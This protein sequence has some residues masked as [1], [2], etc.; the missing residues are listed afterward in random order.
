MSAGD[1]METGGTGYLEH[2]YGTRVTILDNAFLST[3]LARLGSPRIGHPE[4]V[5]ALRILYQALLVNVAGREF[6]RISGEVPT[7]MATAHPAEGVYRGPLLDPGTN[8][9]I[10]DVIRAGLVPSQ[11]C[12]EMLN[13]ALPTVRVRL[14]H[15]TLARRSGEDGHVVGVDLS[16]SKIGG[17][18]EGAVLILPDPMGATGATAIRAVDHYREH[19]GEPAAIIALPMIATPEFLRASLDAI[20]KLTVT[21]LRIDRGLSPPDVLAARPGEFWNRER[22][23]NDHDYIVP[24]AGG[25][26]EVL[27]NSWC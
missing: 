25:M 22:G 1:S 14:D 11:V 18:V 2:G 5:F 27:N 10:A 8:V 7:R 26:G 9:V 4:M 24:G 19:H 20:P 13:S 12:F 23:L 16:G 15:L 3:I 6:S 17:S 21:T